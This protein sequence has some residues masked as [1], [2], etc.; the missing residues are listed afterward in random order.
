M[1]DLT[2][3][4]IRTLGLTG[5]IYNA[6]LLKELVLDSVGQYD[7]KSTSSTAD[8]FTPTFLANMTYR[9]HETQPIVSTSTAPKKSDKQFFKGMYF[10]PF[11]EE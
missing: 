5:V 3:E 8:P 2:T 6:E 9:L 4:E 11:M 1:K 7:M 10:A